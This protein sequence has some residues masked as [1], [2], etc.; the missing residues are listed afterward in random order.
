MRELHL[1]D[2]QR[3]IL[4]GKICPYCGKPTI[5]VDSSIIYGTSYGTI[6]LCEDCEAFVGVHKGTDKALGRVAK[7]EL[8][9]LKREAHKY[10][11]LIW[12]LKYMTR[13]DAYGWLSNLL[14]LPREYTHIGMFQESTCETVIT[15]SK[16]LLN[17]FRALD[18]S[19][20]REPATPYFDI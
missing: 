17:D 4:E 12:Q 19:K 3:L 14:D 8:R 18:I 5:Y 13:Y 1:T 11:D 6:Y 16:L 20:G 2:R 9:Q 10:F 7:R 15:Y